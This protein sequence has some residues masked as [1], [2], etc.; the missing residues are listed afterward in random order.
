[1]SKTELKL[2]TVPVQLKDGTKYDIKVGRGALITLGKEVRKLK[3][4]QKVMIIS[5]EVVAAVYGKLVRARFEEQGYQVHDVVIPTGEE[6]KTLEICQELWQELAQRGFC[7]NDL[8]VAVGGGVVGDMSGFV[9]SAF[10][11][12]IDFVQVPTTLLAMVDASIGGK[13]GVD[14]PCG[15]NLVGAFHQPI[16]T[17]SDVR[18]L[19]TLGKEDWANGFAEI[20]KSA[21]VAP[22]RSFYEWLRDNVEALAGEHDEELLTEVVERTAAFKASVVA[23]DTTESK[24]VRE[25][26]NYGHTLA[27]A[28]ENAA[29]YGTIGH[30]RAVA[31]GMR[32]AARL[33]MQLC[34][35][36][37]D[38]VKRQDAL[39][40]AYGLEELAWTSDA[41]RLL[42]LMKGD[43]KT[44][45]GVIRFVLP[46]DFTKWEIVE[47]PD[48]VLKLHLQAW[49][50]N[51]ERLID[52]R[53]KKVRAERTAK[54]RQQL[55]QMREEK[56]KSNP[57]PAW[58]RWHS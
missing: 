50:I 31:E 25:C 21:M 46:L 54:E 6:N 15:K 3:P 10:M 56:R 41:E 18:A 26:L 30:G 53:A 44:K 14:L 45:D 47:V 40:D 37:V 5:D 13:T 4:C 48:D 32:F 58:K 2:R 28:I 51:K 36:P 55:E 7:R 27:H 49:C 17:C 35:T 23:K 8:V 22:Q 33:G 52:A 1:M 12:G 38:F 16:Y 57:G 29:G 11:R 34:E 20:I 9:A 42:K 39:L 19:K 43:K 24:G